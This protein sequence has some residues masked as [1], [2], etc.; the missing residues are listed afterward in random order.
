MNEIAPEEDG[1]TRNP[2]IYDDSDFYNSL[3]SYYTNKQEGTK[4]PYSLRKTKINKKEVNRKASKGRRLR[5]QVWV[6]SA[7]HTL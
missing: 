2:N 6:P 3:L 7:H 1:L 5:F 4:D